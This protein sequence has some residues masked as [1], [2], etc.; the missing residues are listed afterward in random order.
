MMK[1]SFLILALSL[2]AALAAVPRQFVVVELF[3]STTCTA[4]PGAAYGIDD[5]V[6]N[7]HPVAPVKNHY[8]DDFQ[9]SSTTARRDYYGVTGTPTAY[10]D[11]LDPCTTGSSETSLYPEYLARL[12]TRMFTPSRF[13]IDAAGTLDRLFCSIRIDITK[14]EADTNSNVLL[15]IAVTESAIPH[16]WWPNNTEVNFV[17][18]LMVP[19]HNG[20]PVSVENLAS[21]GRLTEEISFWLKEDWEQANIEIIIWLQ[22]SLTKEILQGAKYRLEDLIRLKTPK[23]LAS[24]EI[25]FLHLSWPPVPFASSYAIW[26]SDSPNGPFSNT[27]WVDEAEYSERLEDLSCKFFRIQALRN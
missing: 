20:S 26:K 19:D 12:N 8:N 25:G 23:A 24:I 6:A 21:G 14:A 1:R 17:N 9:T 2:F 27:I 11:G 3:T 10:F 18:R 13:Q 22:N 15:H 4:C 5:L 7:G 16:T